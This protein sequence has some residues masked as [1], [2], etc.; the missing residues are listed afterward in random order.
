MCSSGS[1]KSGNLHPLL[2]KFNCK[3]SFF[4]FE[5][6]QKLVA[7]ALGVPANRIVVRT[8]RMGKG[9]VKIASMP[10]ATLRRHTP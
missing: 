2:S 7:S 8:K 10:L 5:N 9:D 6:P 3:L 4:F 1:D